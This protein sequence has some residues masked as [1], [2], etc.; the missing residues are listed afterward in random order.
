M[1]E[2]RRTETTDNHSCVQS[3]QSNWKA[4]FRPGPLWGQGTGVPTDSV[5][6]ILTQGAVC[7]LAHHLA[8]QSVSCVC[9]VGPASTPELAQAFVLMPLLDD[10]PHD[11]CPVGSRLAL[12]VDTPTPDSEGLMLS[13]V[14]THTTVEDTE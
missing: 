5:L 14:Y 8:H 2:R 3:T 7:P 13:G 4:R 1:G 10:Y 6:F 9:T 12:S 11:G